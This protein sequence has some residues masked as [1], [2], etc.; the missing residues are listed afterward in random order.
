MTQTKKLVIAFSIFLLILVNLGAIGFAALPFLQGNSIQ[1][2]LRLLPETKTHVT[3]ADIEKSIV[4]IRKRLEKLN[5][6]AVLVERSKVPGEEIVVRIPAT[7]DA[8]KIKQVIVEAGRLAL[9]LVARGTQIPYPSQEAAEKALKTLNNPAFE[10]LPYNT[11]FIE[12]DKVIGFAI[13][14]KKPVITS[15]DLRDARARISD[16]ND[17]DYVIDFSLRPEGAVRMSKA[18]SENVGD[19]LAI[20]LNNEVK[21]APIINGQISDRGQIAGG[22][23]RL[24]AEKLA[25]VLSSG[26]L[27]YEIS[28]VSEKVIS[29]TERLQEKG[30]RVGVFG[31]T[32]LLLLGSF[33]YVVSR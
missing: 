18:T 23:T 21:S 16:Y 4:I 19:Y 7:L 6:N 28:I 32:L 33:F 13:V 31:F 30:V 11:S 27:P 14:E 1:L 26:E 2:G 25:I 29:A 22:F 17:S 20:V 3:D 24:E 9:K 8:A 10:I 15:L 5:S 12:K